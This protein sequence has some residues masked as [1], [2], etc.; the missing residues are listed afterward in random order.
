MYNRFKN[1]S[2]NRLNKKSV[3]FIAAGLTTALVA[4]SIVIP[5]VAASGVSEISNASISALVEDYITESA[6]ADPVVT[7]KK[8]AGQSIK[9]PDFLKRG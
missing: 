6:A 9:I 1:W 8:S 7:P 5:T 3:R 2:H 4:T